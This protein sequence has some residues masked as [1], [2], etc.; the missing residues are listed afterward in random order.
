MGVIS[1]NIDLKEVANGKKTCNVILAVKRSYKNSNNQYDTDFITCKA[2]GQKAELISQYCKKGDMIGIKGSIF[3][4][5]YEKDGKKIYTQDIF[6][7]DIN[8]VKQKNDNNLI[9][10]EEKSQDL[11]GEFAEENDGLNL[12]F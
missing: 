9:K 5:S 11:Y 3:T 6:I 10:K 8:F 7:Q 4:G 12:P 2:F 1:R